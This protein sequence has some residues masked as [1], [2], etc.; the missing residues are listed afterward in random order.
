[1]EMDDGYSFGIG[2]FETML[3]YGDRCV[4]AEKHISRLSAALAS[5]G[6]D[7]RLSAEDLE[8]EVS[9]GRL[10]GR[11][12]KVMVSERNT[13]FADRPFPYM[14]DKYRDG[15]RIC[16]SQV[17]RNET[18]PFTYIKSLQYGEN[19]TEKRKASASGFDEC[20]FLNSKGQ[21]CEGSSCNIF[22]CDDD[23]IVTPPVSC[24]LLPG[25]VREY[26]L[27]NYDVSERTLVPEDIDGFDSCFVTNS[28]MGIMPVKSIDGRTFDGF[29][30]AEDLRREYIE[31]VD[32]GL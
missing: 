19:I 31:R 3:V 21:I 26:L 15:L 1:M 24:G 9:G 27:D 11:V 28:V 5:L 13:I 16:R 8:C 30:I 4:M 2:A 22:F 20:V 25:T 32:G 23:E 12:L 29:R 18:S 7:R 17:M 10:D 6:I 14:P